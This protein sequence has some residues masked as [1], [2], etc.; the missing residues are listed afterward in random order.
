MRRFK[1]LSKSDRIRIETLNN[2]GK[3]PKE[4]AEVVGVHIST[5]YRELQRGQYTHR[6]SD[7]TE[8]TRY[9]SDLSEMKYRAN[10]A[11][12]G[13]DLKIGN[14]H[15]LAEYIE[16][17][18][19]DEKYSPEAVLGEI[20]AQG[21][22]FNTEIKSKNT[23]YSYIEKG[24]FLRL[25]NKNLPVLWSMLRVVAFAFLRWPERAACLTVW[26][27]SFQSGRRRSFSPMRLLPARPVPVW[28]ILEKLRSI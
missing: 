23:I 16:T 26:F 15:R 20:K 17:K 7:W 18:I 3:T 24:I 8:E 13:A 14:D 9:S 10:L 1:H 12:K 25:T 6:N 19:A 11:A 2:D 4:I 5:I 28:W 27:A 22:Q 21:L